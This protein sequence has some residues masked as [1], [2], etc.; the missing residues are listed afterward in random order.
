MRVAPK[1]GFRVY[2]VIAGMPGPTYLIISTVEDYAQ[3]DETTAAD[4]ASVKGMTADESAARLKFQTEGVLSTEM[5]RY[6]LDPKQSYVSKET[7]AKDP[8]F[9][10]AK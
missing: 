6:R 2:E 7:R 10:S 3:F 4:L 5:N 1:L 8:A 9:W